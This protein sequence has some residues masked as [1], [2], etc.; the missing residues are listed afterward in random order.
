[1][2]I[3]SSWTVV[4]GEPALWPGMRHCSNPTKGVLAALSLLLMSF[5]TSAVRCRRALRGD[6]GQPQYSQRFRGHGSRQ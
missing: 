1:M 3:D 5:G 4:A 2:S 6:R